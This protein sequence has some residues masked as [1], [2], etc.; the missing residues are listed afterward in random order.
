MRTHNLLR[1][2]TVVERR[3]LRGVDDSDAERLT[4]LPGVHHEPDG[5]Y[6][7]HATHKTHQ[8]LD[9]ATLAAL[10]AECVANGRH[11][12]ATLDHPEEGMVIG[13]T[14]CHRYWRNHADRDRR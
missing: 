10:F 1:G 2:V 11:H 12:L 7:P 8:E 6:Y 14:H 9:E 5:I 13:C 4:H 3:S